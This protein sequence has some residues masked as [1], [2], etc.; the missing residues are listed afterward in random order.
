[1]AQ[2]L[3]LPDGRYVDYRVYGPKDGFPLVWIHGTPGS[4]IPVPNVI[5]SGEKKGV[6][7]IAL[8]RAGYGGSTRNRGR[9]IV[10]AVADLHAL[11]Q[12]LGV[13]KCIV[14]GWSGGG[15]LTSF[16]ESC[17]VMQIDIAR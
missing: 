7:V 16:L 13:E 12:H 6:K 14:G 4:Y 2:Q 9:R 10:D 3:E 15:M 1:M 11:N 5:T 17:Q 8:S